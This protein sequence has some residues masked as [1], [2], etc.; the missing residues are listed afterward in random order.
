MFSKKFRLTGFLL[1]EPKPKMAAKMALCKMQYLMHIAVR[2]YRIVKIILLSHSVT[3]WLV[4]T[5]IMTLLPD[6]VNPSFLIFDICSSGGEYP[7][8][9]RR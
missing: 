9:L 6:W 1:T 7:G 3:Y 8:Q 2:Q 4:A 5:P